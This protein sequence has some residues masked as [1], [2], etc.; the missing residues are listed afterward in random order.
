MSAC[1]CPFFRLAL[2][3][4]TSAIKQESHDRESVAALISGPLRPRNKL[5]VLCRP[6]ARQFRWW[7]WTAHQFL[8]VEF[9]CVQVTLTF[10]TDALPDPHGRRSRQFLQNAGVGLARTLQHMKG[11]VRCFDHVQCRSR[12]E[13][14]TN[15]SQELKIGEGVASSLE[16]KHWQSDIRQVLRTFRSRFIRR[17]Q[18]ETE[19]HQPAKSNQDVLSGSE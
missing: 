15:G 17:V 11:V 1:L 10:P 8:L 12:S 4:R 18:R 9:E 2:P 16:K 14:G 19:E 13:F 3:Y 7:I 5:I 6:H